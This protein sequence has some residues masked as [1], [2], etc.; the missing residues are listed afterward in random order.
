MNVLRFMGTLNWIWICVFSGTFETHLA[1]LNCS[2]V[3]AVRGAGLDKHS[4]IHGQSLRSRLDLHRAVAVRRAGGDQ[5]SPSD[6]WR[7]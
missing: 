7:W 6:S 2:T 1:G 5:T 3:G 4:V